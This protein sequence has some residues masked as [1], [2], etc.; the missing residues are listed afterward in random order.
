M[1]AYKTREEGAVSDFHLVGNRGGI[2]TSY[3]DE[4]K[5]EKVPHSLKTFIFFIFPFRHYLCLILRLSFAFTHAI[6]SFLIQ[7]TQPFSA[8]VRYQLAT[9][10][11]KLKFT[12]LRSS[13]VLKLMSY[14]KFPSP[15]R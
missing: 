2:R 12:L 6:N 3:G 4:E 14:S 10:S 7:D 13:R 5:I 1:A 15:A 11:G 8:L 9:F